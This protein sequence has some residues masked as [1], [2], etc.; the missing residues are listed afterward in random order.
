MAVSWGGSL[1]SIEV[2]DA[3]A[4][5]SFRA[6]GGDLTKAVQHRPRLL[7]AVR[8]GVWK[9]IPIG[10]E[11]AGERGRGLEYLPARTVFSS[12]IAA[13]WTRWG[14]VWRAP[15]GGIPKKNHREPGP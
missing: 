5:E 7:V 4:I 6:F 3:R 2:A 1:P 15:D 8:C 12:R 13:F 9:P 14:R 11:L 10:N